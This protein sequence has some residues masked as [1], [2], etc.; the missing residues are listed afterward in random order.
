MPAV[1]RDVFPNFAHV[2]FHLTGMAIPKV[3]AD[4]AA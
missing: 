1:S 2:F 4:R 3:V